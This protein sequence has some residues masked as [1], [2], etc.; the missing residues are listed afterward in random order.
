MADK[1]VKKVGHPKEDYQVEKQVATSGSDKK[2][3]KKPE[4]E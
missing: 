1:K 4:K 2:E 3:D